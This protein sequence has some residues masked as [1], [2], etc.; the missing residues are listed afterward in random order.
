[1]ETRLQ[2]YVEPERLGARREVV[3]GAI[4]A[5]KLMRLGSQYR[6]AEPVR[7]RLEFSPGK[8][9]RTVVH[10]RLSTVLKA[11]C[12]RCLEPVDV[13]VEQTLALELVDVD[14]LGADV[15]AIGEDFDDAVEYHGKLDLHELIEDELVLACPIIP[16]HLGGECAMPGET[17]AGAP[18]DDLAP[19]GGETEHSAAA[20]RKPFAGLAELLGSS[21]KNKPS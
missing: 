5:A 17:S 2:K 19:G 20:T 7:V 8:Q 6:S 9:G 4:P 12:Q 18:S 13:A 11:T 15:Q 1:M 3:E 10:G 16:Q 21:E 14:A